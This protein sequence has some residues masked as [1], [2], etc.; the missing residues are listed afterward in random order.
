MKHAQSAHFDN[1]ATA[2]HPVWRKR[3]MKPFTCRAVRQQLIAQAAVM[4]EWERAAYLHERLTDLD[5]ALD[6]TE[7]DAIERWLD[8]EELLQGCARI[9]D[10]D[11]GSRGSGQPTPLAD[12]D[13]DALKAH[14]AAK[15][16]LLHTHRASL[17]VLADM[18]QAGEWRLYPQMIGRIRR[19][20]RELTKVHRLSAHRVHS[21]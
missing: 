21:T 1:I 13:M 18:M 9:V 2:S 6:C 16:A 12:D 20:A 7:A 11:G 19:A 4:P 10:Y 14:A 5:R 15:Q 3:Q 8:C 17:R